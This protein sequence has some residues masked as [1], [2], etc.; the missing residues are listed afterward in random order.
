MMTIV[1]FILLVVVASA[2]FNKRLN[3]KAEGGM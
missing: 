3:K 1:V 2:M